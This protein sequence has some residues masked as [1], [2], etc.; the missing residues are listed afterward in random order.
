M[1]KCLWMKLTLKSLSRNTVQNLDF[2]GGQG[3]RSPSHIYVLTMVITAGN[4]LLRIVDR[5]CLAEPMVENRAGPVP[6]TPGRGWEHISLAPGWPFILLHFSPNTTTPG[7]SHLFHL[8]TVPLPFSLYSPVYK[9]FCLAGGFVTLPTP[10]Y[11]RYCSVALAGFLDFVQD[12]LSPS[13]VLHKNPPRHQSVQH[14]ILILSCG[15][16][17]ESPSTSSPLMMSD[18][19]LHCCFPTLWEIFLSHSHWLAF[20]CTW[21]FA[22]SR[23]TFLNLKCPGTPSACPSILSPGLQRP[24]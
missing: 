10:F 20:S 15:S 12:S 13:R 16:H 23:F 5:P 8:S 11:S 6:S 9:V 18:S 14:T 7:L 4:D 2:S 1:K 22:Q 21:S 19:S 3:W 24:L 17:L